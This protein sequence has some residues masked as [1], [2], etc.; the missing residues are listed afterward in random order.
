MKVRISAAA[1]HDLEN[2][3]DWIARDHPKRAYRYFLALRRAALEIGKNPRVFSL[4]PGLE[5]LGYRR[6]V[7][8]QHLIFFVIAEDTVEVVRI[9]HGAQDR[10]VL[11]D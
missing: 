3:A 10:S 2:I 7:Y 5:D 1:E 6:R 8:G 9:L 4:A 11:D